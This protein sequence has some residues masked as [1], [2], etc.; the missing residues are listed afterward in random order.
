MSSPTSLSST[1][2]STYYCHEC[3]ERHGLLNG[4]H[5]PSTNPSSFQI[6]KA[7]KHAGPTSTSTGINSVLNSGSTAEQDY[8]ARRALEAGFLE[9]EANGCRSLVYQSSA[10]V[11]TRFESATPTEQLDSFRWV[12]STAST[13]AH[14][15]PVSSAKYSG[16]TC[17]DCSCSVSS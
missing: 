17:V 7:R 13:L 5:P 6:V 10:D 16:A 9:V 1:T 2:G 12:L 14:G 8:L 11:G 4:L 3:A 15:Y